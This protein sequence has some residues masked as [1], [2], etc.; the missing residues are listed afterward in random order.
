[1]S[2]GAILKYILHLLGSGK[3]EVFWWIFGILAL[4]VFAVLG[5]AYICFRMTFYISN[6]EKRENALRTV[7]PGKEYAPFYD[8]MNG[9]NKEVATFSFETFTI[10]SFDGLTLK[11]KYY[12]KFP[13]A[14]IELMF[15]GYRGNAQRD[16]CGGV[17]RCFRLGRNAMIIDQ[18][19]SG[20]SDGHVITF[21]IKESADCY[22][23]VKYTVAR[24]G[25]EK[26]II[27]GGISMGAAT[28][29]MATR[30]DLPKN[31]VCVLADCGYTSPK[32]IIKK[33]V[34]EMKLPADLIYPFIRLGALI[35]GRFN[36]EETSAMETMKKCT[37]PVVFVHGDD[38]AFVPYDMSVRLHDAC[39]SEKKTLITIH[40]AGHGLAFPVDQDGYVNQLA[41][42][43]DSWNL[44]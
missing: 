29:M 1:M 23:W 19:A 30:F 12:E 36:L 3:L 25:E 33:V 35:Y 32:E 24:F 26:K 37:V 28:V 43:R 39:T 22:E 21:G 16:L 8:M 2:N 9:W 38:D 31:V 40:G 41:E 15:H 4:L 5:I 14:P 7:P 34:K 18:R 44:K 11:G 6:K 17:E 27:I 10:K 42:V 20:R 13:G